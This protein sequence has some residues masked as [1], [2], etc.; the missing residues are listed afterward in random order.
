M[1]LLRK[2]PPEGDM[3]LVETMASDATRVDMDP[4]NAILRNQLA[5]DRNKMMENKVQVGDDFVELPYPTS[6]TGRADVDSTPYILDLAGVPALMRGAGKMLFKTGVKEGAESL[7]KMGSKEA[8]EGVQRKQANDRLQNVADRA[9]RSASQE[10]S[11]AIL[12]LQ[13]KLDEALRMGR[14]EESVAEQLFEESVDNIFH[15]ARLDDIVLGDTDKLAKNL[16]P[17]MRELYETDPDLFD[18][19][20]YGDLISP[21]LLKKFEDSTPNFFLNQFGGRV[22]VIKNNDL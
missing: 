4:V 5:E 16:G 13:G 20:W 11:Q 18:D 17:T 9:L 19:L 3:P 15:Q 7:M 21:S 10:E 2:D 6:W 22:R 1:K 12:N 8:L 14:I